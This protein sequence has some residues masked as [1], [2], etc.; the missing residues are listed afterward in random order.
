LYRTIQFIYLSYTMNMKDK[1]SIKPTK[2][3]FE[4]YQNIFDYFNKSLFKGKLPQ[5]I[6]N[7]SR[8]SKA[9]GFF[10]RNRWKHAENGSSKHE[11]SLNPI[12][13]G[14]NTNYIIQTLVHE[15]CHL[16]QHEFGKPSRTG[17]HNKQWATKMEEIG[18][19]SSHTGLPNGRKTGQ[20]MSDYLLKGGLLERKIKSMPKRYLLPFNSIEAIPIIDLGSLEEA[21]GMLKK[22]PS[23]KNKVKYTCSEC[24]MN[25]WGKPDLNIV[26]GDCQETL[27]VE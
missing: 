23:K 13:L 8:K 4:A 22:E 16:W 21:I 12:I 25:V 3:Q 19:I 20:H 7:F 11:I 9:A 14:K 26:C 5:C 24:Q 15:M 6:L 27:E 18:L 2:E 1:T 10:A 17:Y